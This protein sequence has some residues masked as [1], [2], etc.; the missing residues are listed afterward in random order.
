MI[1]RVDPERTRI[2]DY[3]RQQAAAKSIDELVERVDEAVEELETAARAF[4]PATIA[5]R[6]DG[7]GWAP[8]DCVRHIAGNNVAVA[9]DVLHVAWTGELAPGPEPPA[10]GTRDEVLAAMRVALDS[11][12]VHVREADPAANLG[13][14]WPHPM[15]GDLNW[16]EWLLFI[17]IH[18]RDHA[19]QLA[20]MAAAPSSPP[21]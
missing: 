3:L 8:L 7:E 21:A 10:S 4:E 20:A 9:R 11:L 17:R 13:T 16:R 19:R 5:Q 2:R 6:R 12:Y 18:S 14:T 15:F 1:G